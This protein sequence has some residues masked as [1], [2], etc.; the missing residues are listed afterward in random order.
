MPLS[1]HTAALLQTLRIAFRNIFRNKVRTT[2]TLAAIA[3]GGISLIL[4]GG[5][6]RDIFEQLREATIHSQL[7]HLQVYREGF[8]E[9]GTAQPFQ[10]IIP[11]PQKVRE[12]ISATPGVSFVT[13]RLEFSGLLSS[14]ETT[15][16]FLAQGVDPAMEKRLGTFVVMSEGDYLSASDRYG[17]ILGRGLAASINVKVGDTVTLLTNTRAGS[18]NAIQVKVRGIF[19]TFYKEYDDRALKIPLETAQELLQ[20]DGIQSLVVVLKRTDDTEAVRKKLA[21][22]FAETRQPIEIKSWTELAEFYQK[23]VDLY[24]RQFTVIKVI[25]TIVV[26]LSIGNTMSMSIYERT[27]EI[28]TVMAIGSRRRSVLQMFLLEGLVL[29]ILG[30]LA[31]LLLGILLAQIVSLIGIPMPPAPGSTV[32]YTARIQVYPGILGFAFG[33]S[34]VTSIISSIYPSLKASRLEIVDALRHNV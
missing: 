15:T 20:H 28:G 34:I 8:Y 18:I 14:G 33:L 10:Y 13:P 6:I 16:S 30:G 7:G 31:G 2:I 9:K 11:D 21:A 29:G 22:S 23:V 27:G 17:A 32:P 12:T 5:F 26:I 4:T 19:Y 24:S 3:F 1:T 25:I